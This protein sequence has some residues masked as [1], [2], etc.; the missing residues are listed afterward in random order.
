MVRETGANL[1]QQQQGQTSPKQFAYTG[2]K[3]AVD[4]VFR[5]LNNLGLDKI[6]TQVR[7]KWVRRVMLIL[8]LRVQRML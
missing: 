6:A 2:A 8:L 1:Q 3:R 7:R 5:H 4:T